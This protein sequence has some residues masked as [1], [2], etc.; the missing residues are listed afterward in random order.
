M[1]KVRIIEQGFLAE[2]RKQAIDNDTKEAIRRSYDLE[3]E[4]KL[5]RRAITA[6]ADTLKV[7]LPEEFI[8]YNALVKETVAKGKA[9]KA[10]ITSKSIK[11]RKKEDKR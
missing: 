4:I 9:K 11:I 7:K 3:D 10:A 6:I 1:G 5:L 2:E 8:I